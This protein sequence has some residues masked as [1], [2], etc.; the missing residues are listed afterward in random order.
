MGESRSKTVMK[1][2]AVIT[3]PNSQ[4]F[5]YN[6]AESLLVLPKYDGPPSTRFK[7]NQLR[8]GMVFL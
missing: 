7:L 6:E 1:A 3:T 4:S 5:Q 2:A 8:L